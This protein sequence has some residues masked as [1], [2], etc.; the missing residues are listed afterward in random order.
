MTQSIYVGNLPFGTSE[1]ELRDLFEQHGEVTSV[2]LIIDRESGRPRGFGFV[3]MPKDVAGLAISAL[4][5][6]DLGGRPIRV[7][8]AKAR[9]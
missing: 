6:S 3:E 9:S 5:E 7:N 4:N 1:Q 8:E 2:N